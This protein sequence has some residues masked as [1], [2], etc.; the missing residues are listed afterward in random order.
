MARV[1]RAVNSK[2]KRRTLQERTKGYYGTSS[3]TL[4]GMME[5]DRHSGLYQYRDRRAKKREFRSLWIQRIDAAARQNDLSYSTLMHGLKLAG[6]ELDRKVLA[7]IAYSDADT[8]ADIAA[9]A[10]KALADAE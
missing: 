7:E 2:K 9:Q 1:K 5:Q 10:K 3:R 6:I 8:F 4:R